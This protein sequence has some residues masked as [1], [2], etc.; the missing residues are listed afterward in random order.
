MRRSYARRKLTKE[1]RVANRVRAVRERGRARAL[2]LLRRIEGELSRLLQ[3]EQD[4]HRSPVRENRPY[5]TD[6][7]Y[8]KIGEARHALATAPRA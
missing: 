3:G 2:T 4:R 7:G 8:R 5:F 6:A 1:E